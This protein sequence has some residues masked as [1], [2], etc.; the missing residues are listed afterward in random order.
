[1]K[2]KGETI[3]SQAGLR[4]YNLLLKFEF[5]DDYASGTVA[6]TLR[7]LCTGERLCQR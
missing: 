2:G 6:M 7:W 1:M 4:G 5:W 3:A